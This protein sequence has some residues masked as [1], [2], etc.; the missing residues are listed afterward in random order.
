MNTT[1]IKKGSS[2]FLK[3]SENPDEKKVRKIFSNEYQERF[4]HEQGSLS[5]NDSGSALL[6]LFPIR[7]DV[8][9]DYCVQ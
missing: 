1:K 2:R 6:Y 4:S 7:S 9:C 5:V 3:K 8:W